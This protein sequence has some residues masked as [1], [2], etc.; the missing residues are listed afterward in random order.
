MKE[1][2]LSLHHGDM[3]DMTCDDEV[4]ADIKDIMALTCERNERGPQKRNGMGALLVLVV[5]RLDEVGAHMMFA[6]D[7][8]FRRKHFLIFLKD[9]DAKEASLF[10]EIA[11]DRAFRQA[12]EN[13]RRLKGERCERIHGHA[14]S[15]AAFF[16]QS[17]D[18][19]AC[20]EMPQRFSE[21]FFCKRQRTR[22]LLW[23][24]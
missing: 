5:I 19:N 23:L 24:S 18:G 2:R 9:I 12:P 16:F 8:T 21:F 11:I 10:E 4:I 13:E 6:F 3:L 22:P 17:D 15:A 20:G 1:Q 14:Q 7:G